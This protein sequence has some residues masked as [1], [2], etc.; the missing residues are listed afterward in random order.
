MFCTSRSSLF[1]C[2]SKTF[3]A[4]SHLV[5]FS[6]SRSCFRDFPNYPRPKHRDEQTF[7]RSC[8]EAST[9]SAE[10]EWSPCYGS[11]VKNMIRGTWLDLSFSLH[12]E[13]SIRAIWYYCTRVKFTLFCVYIE[14]LT[15]SSQEP[16]KKKSKRD[17]RLF[18][19]YSECTCVDDV[20]C[21]S[22]HQRVR[23]IWKNTRLIKY[24]GSEPQLRV[25]LQ[26]R[27]RNR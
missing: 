13:K 9:L 7:S 3:P 27:M 23:T 26:E 16:P 15:M 24:K 8:F 5:S 2:F 17:N 6:L 19:L 4:I 22:I 18:R 12:V 25:F 11:H 14:R 10:W 21:A 20:F 1:P